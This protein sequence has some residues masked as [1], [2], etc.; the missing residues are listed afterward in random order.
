MPKKRWDQLLGSMDS[1]DSH[2]M[3]RKK[4]AKKRKRYD[5]KEEAE[6]AARR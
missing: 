5:T 1:S 4:K 3:K 2:W 6:A